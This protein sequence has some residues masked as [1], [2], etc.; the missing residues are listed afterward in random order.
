LV[1][2]SLE[3]LKVCVFITVA[4]AAEGY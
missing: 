2:P 4:Q 3:H 1:L